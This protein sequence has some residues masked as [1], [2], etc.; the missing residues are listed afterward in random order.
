MA[1]FRALVARDYQTTLAGRLKRCWDAITSG[2][3]FPDLSR[4]DSDARCGTLDAAAVG[5]QTDG[6][7]REDYFS[8]CTRVRYMG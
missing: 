2:H 4:E 1:A 6:S 8:E 5:L 7:S 3:V